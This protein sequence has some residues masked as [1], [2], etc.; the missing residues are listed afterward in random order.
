MMRDMAAYSF[1]GLDRSQLK[2]TATFKSTPDPRMDGT[3]RPRVVS[4]WRNTRGRGR[5]PAPKDQIV[6]HVHHLHALEPERKLDSIVA[7]VADFHRVCRAIV[8]RA[9]REHD[10][11][12]PIE[13]AMIVTWTSR[14]KISN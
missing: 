9:R 10:P 5:P 13:G 8:F 14:N 1:E 6:G 11:E 4:E 3:G 12:K 2:V 7:E